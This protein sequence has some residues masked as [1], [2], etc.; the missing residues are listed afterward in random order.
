MISVC[1]ATYNGERYVR[2]QIETILPQLDAKDEIIVSDDGSTDETLNIIKSFKDSRIKILEGIS[3]CSPIK[4]FERAL[5]NVHGD[6]VFLSD[7]DDK[8]MPNKIEM[9]MRYLRFYDCVVSDNIVVDGNDEII[10]PS[11][12]KQNGTHVGKYYNLFIK[13]GY[14]G[15]CMAFDRKVLEASLP[16]PNDIPMHDIWIGNVA[17]FR[18]RLKFIPD[19]LI[20]FCRHG[21][22]ASTSAS[23]SKYNFFRRFLFRYNTWKY[24]IRR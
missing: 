17:A 9:M 13:N 21:D 1:I 5:A 4:N 14:L 11:F 16:F 20:Y 10:S 12:Y 6:Y 7:Q 22:N 24:L 23:E 18:F 8:W 19:K 15:C 3:N 2:N